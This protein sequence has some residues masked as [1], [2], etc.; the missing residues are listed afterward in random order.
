MRTMPDPTALGREEAL[1]RPAA[2]LAGVA[3]AVLP[4]GRARRL[5]EGEPLGHALHPLLTDLPIGFWTSA[6]LLDLLAPRRGRRAAQALVGWGVVSAVP[7]MAAGLADWSRID[8]REARR[9]GTVHATA[10][11]A[12]TGCYA[13]SY[14]ARR[15]SMGVR[16]VVWGLLGAAV[17]TA[18]GYLGGHL[19]FGSSEPADTGSSDD[20]RQPTDTGATG[21]L[22]DAERPVTELTP[23]RP[24]TA[25]GTIRPTHRRTG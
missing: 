13:L 7:T 18:G 22:G 9:I 11:A 6:N 17:A 16:G 2:V 21:T 19:V 3:D 20:D 5:L 10:N 24:D 14:V 1:D 23:R 4:D 8:D 25:P 12:A 15:R